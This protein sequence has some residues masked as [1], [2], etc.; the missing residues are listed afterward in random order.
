MIVSI[1]IA[2]LPV[3]RSPMISSRWPR[4]IG[5]IESIA[6]S[7]VSI[8]SRT[9][10]RC[11][12]PGALN[13]TGRVPEGRMSPLPSKGLPSGS[14]IRPSIS[15][16]TG[17]SKSRLVRRTVSPSTTFSQSPN[18]TAPTLSDSRLSASPVTSWGNSSISKDM[19][20]SSPCTRQLPSATDS[21][22]PT[23]VRSA[24]LVSSP[25]MRLLRIEVISSG[26]ICMLCGSLAGHGALSGLRARLSKLVQSVSDRGVKDDI[27]DP[28]DD[29]ANQLGVD[30]ARQLDFLARTLGD[31]IAD[32]L[33]RC[34]VELDGA[35][36]LNGQELVLLVPQPLELGPHP[37]DDGH[38]LALDQRL[39]EVHEQRVGA[40]DRPIQRVL[41]LRGREVWR[42]E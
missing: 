30:P 13:S 11:T 20:F 12:T 42:E 16:P 36:D 24:P 41:L 40:L 7:P 32:P 5:I 1:A 15:S 33:D 28:Q 6:F 18:I 2:V 22:V 35:G 23:S 29:S 25:S 37:E 17:I 4:P 27:P 10:W 14:T 38:A 21:T 3:W 34:L 19:Q 31:A 39:E 26:L 8:G 9:G